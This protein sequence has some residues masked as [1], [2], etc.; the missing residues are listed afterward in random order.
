MEISCSRLQ[1]SLF[2]PAFNRVTTSFS[3]SSI[4]QLHGCIFATGEVSLPETGSGL[5]L[6]YV[7]TLKYLGKYISSLVMLGSLQDV[8]RNR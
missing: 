1:L 3:V 6:Q 7:D 4:I 5:F 8:V 2:V